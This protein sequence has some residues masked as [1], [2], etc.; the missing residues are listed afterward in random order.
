MIMYR[1]FDEK[2]NMPCT[3]FHGVNGSRQ[4]PLNEWVVS[5]TKE[6]YDGNKKKSTKYISGFHVLTSIDDV[7]KFLKKFRNLDNRVVCAVDVDIDAGIWD[8]EHSPGKVKLVKKLKI[9][10]EYWDSRV[11]AS[12]LCLQ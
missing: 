2:N 3:L 7:T 1:I 10:G 8:K 4:L 12:E 11:K 5:Q 9:P 6:V